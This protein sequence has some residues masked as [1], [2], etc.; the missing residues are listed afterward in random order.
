MWK[1]ASKLGSLRREDFV[2]S[3]PFLN[4]ESLG[5]KELPMRFNFAFGLAGFARQLRDLAPMLSVA[6]APEQDIQSLV[7]T[8][9]ESGCTFYRSGSTHNSAAAADHMRL[10]LRRGKR[11]AKT[12]VDFIENLATKSSWTGRLYRIECESGQLEPLNE[13]LTARLVTLRTGNQ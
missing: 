1:T 5:W 2:R 10:K 6:V 3:A 4:S 7:T 11:Y 13:W 8:V 12:A 9:E